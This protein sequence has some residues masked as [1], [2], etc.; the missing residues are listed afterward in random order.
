MSGHIHW[1][2]A[3]HRRLSLNRAHRSPT[4]NQDPDT[5]HSWSECPMPLHAGL[6]WAGVN[7]ALTGV[8][9]CACVVE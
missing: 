7:A 2:P 6:N 3:S 8:C 1:H 9:L 5:L 4:D